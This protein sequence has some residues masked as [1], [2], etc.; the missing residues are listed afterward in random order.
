MILNVFKGLFYKSQH[1]VN[2]IIKKQDNLFFSI[3]NCILIMV[4]EYKLTII[5]QVILPHSK[6]DILNDLN[7]A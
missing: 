5:S 3:N 4:T 2:T 1:F 7:H 6:D